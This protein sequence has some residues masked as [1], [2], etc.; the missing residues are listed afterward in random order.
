MMAG[1]KILGPSPILIP[2]KFY[3]SFLGNGA[4]R[5]V[6]MT[7]DPSPISFIR[8]GIRYT[9]SHQSLVNSQS[10]EEY[11]KIVSVWLTDS[12]IAKALLHTCHTLSIV[13]HI[14]QSTDMYEYYA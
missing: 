8:R 1:S 7:P 3:F 2:F 4:M 14:L 10:L 12:I 6:D 11:K 9:D 5:S 13:H